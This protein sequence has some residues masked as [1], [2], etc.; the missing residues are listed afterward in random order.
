MRIFATRWIAECAV[1]SVVEHLPD[2]EGVTGSNPVSR[3]IPAFSPGEMLK[4]PLVDLRSTERWVFFL[5][6]E[7]VAE[8]FG[9]IGGENS[10]L[11]ER[12]ACPG[13]IALFVQ[14][15]CGA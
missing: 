12:A 14:G 10:K 2:T 13:I 4:Q 6:A 7:V 8:G 3:T 5:Q 1:S 9:L 15:H 11:V